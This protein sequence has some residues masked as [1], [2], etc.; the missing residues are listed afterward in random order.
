MMIIRKHKSLAVL[1]AIGCHAP[2]VLADKASV[3]IDSPVNGAELDQKVRCRVY[4]EIT[5][6]SKG[7]HAYLYL[8]DKRVAMLRRLKDSYILDPL[9]PGKHEIC[10]KIVTGGHTPIGVQQC[11]KISVEK[12]VVELKETPLATHIH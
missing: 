2:L 7:D 10:I 1:L 12:H 6:R 4:Y 8:D 11:N 9:A 3:S 5:L